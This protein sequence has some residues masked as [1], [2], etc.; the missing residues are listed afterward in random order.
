VNLLR[1]AFAAG[2][3]RGLDIHQSYELQRIRNFQPFVALVTPEGADAPA[4]AR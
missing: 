1:N 3:F 4:P 2:H